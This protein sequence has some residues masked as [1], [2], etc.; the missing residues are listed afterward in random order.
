MAEVGIGVEEEVL[1]SWWCVRVETLG[2]GCLLFEGKSYQNQKHATAVVVMRDA[3]RLRMSLRVG[4]CGL[5]DKDESALHIESTAMPL[6][7]SHIYASSSASKKM[8]K[9]AQLVPIDSKKD[10][11]HEM[12]RYNAVIA[13]SLNSGTQQQQQREDNDGE[14]NEV[15]PTSYNISTAMSMGILGSDEQLCV[16][17]ND[18]VRQLNAEIELAEAEKHEQ[19]RSLEH[20]ISELQSKCSRLQRR[21]DSQQRET[22][23]KELEARDLRDQLKK[24]KLRTAQLQVRLVAMELKSNKGWN[25]VG[26]RNLQLQRT[27]R[28]ELNRKIELDKERERRA[29]AIRERDEM[30]RSLRPLRQKNM[31]IQYAL[32]LKEEEVRKVRAGEDKLTSS[33]T[34]EKQYAERMERQAQN[35]A[36]ER[37]MVL[38]DASRKHLQLQELHEEVNDLMENLCQEQNLRHELE[39]N[40]Y[41]KESELSSAESHILALESELRLEKERAT[42]RK[43]DIEKT[44]LEASRLRMELQESNKA[45]Q[46]EQEANNVRTLSFVNASICIDHTRM[47]TLLYTCIW[48]MISLFVSLRSV[49]ETE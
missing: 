42:Q 34:R 32:Q 9:E 48:L 49:R 46:M 39:V 44:E 14:D 3:Q 2:T 8:E 10:K 7:A 27:R 45:L 33:L 41:T 22:Y 1:P 17:L 5:A 4:G 20:R 43:Q 15:S 31:E 23:E 30:A 40:M 37:T 47:A 18:R 16:E 35:L 13:G 29:L 19:W 25:E 12:D 11:V 28:I 6:R 24:S 38:E 21:F 26:D 36:Q